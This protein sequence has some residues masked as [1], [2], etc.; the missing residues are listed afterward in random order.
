MNNTTNNSKTNNTEI[1]NS[2]NRS[3]QLNANNDQDSNLKSH[4]IY[5]RFLPGLLMLLLGVAFATTGVVSEASA[6]N[7]VFDWV[8]NMPLDG[9]QQFDTNRDGTVDV[10]NYDTNRDGQ[11]DAARVDSNRDG[12][13]DVVAL[14]TNRNGDYDQLIFDTNRDGHLETAIID[15]N[16]DRY[17]DL[18]GYDLNRTG[19][20]SGWRRYLPP[21]IVNVPRRK[22]GIANPNFL[23]GNDYYKIW[24]AIGNSGSAWTR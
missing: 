5:R 10:I 11:V 2:I 20:Y 14:D 21:A 16:H 13:L 24:T 19:Y 12:Y 3:S 7:T 1:G 17:L 8:S 6:Q 9:G 23:T 18:V 4:S 15:S 22:G